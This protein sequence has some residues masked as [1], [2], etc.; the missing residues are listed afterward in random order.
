MGLNESSIHSVLRT[1][2]IEIDGVVEAL[3]ELS[4]VWPGWMDM[5]TG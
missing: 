4:R 3:A 1:E 2:A 5:Q